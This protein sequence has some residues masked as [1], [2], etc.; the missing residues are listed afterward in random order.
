MQTLSSCIFRCGVCSFR[1]GFAASY[2]GDVVI[3]FGHSG[4]LDKDVSDMVWRKR[5]PLSLSDAI[6]V[7]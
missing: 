2:L 6:V 7:I 1:G 4:P 5:S 3:H